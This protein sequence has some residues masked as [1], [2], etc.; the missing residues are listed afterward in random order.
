M[1]KPLYAVV[2]YL[3]ILYERGRLKMIN[4][5]ATLIKDARDVQAYF[6]QVKEHA[7]QIQKNI[8]YERYRTLQLDEALLD[9]IHNAQE[10]IDEIDNQL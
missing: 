4:I 1:Q 10:I 2:T 5:D 6:K 3:Y 9:I 8:E 7:E